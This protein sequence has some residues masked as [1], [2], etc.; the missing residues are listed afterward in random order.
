[1]N[2]KLLLGC[3]ISLVALILIVAFILYTR[4]KDNYH[5]QLNDTPLK[6]PYCNNAGGYVGNYSLEDAMANHPDLHP[7]WNF[8]WGQ[9]KK[10]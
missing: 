2:E 6:Y 8:A 10:A 9:V 3:G 5:T 1:M 4:R 7:C